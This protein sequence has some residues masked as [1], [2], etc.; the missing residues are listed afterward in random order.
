MT[1]RE[2][3]EFLSDYLSNDLSVVEKASFEE[4]VRECAACTRYLEGFAATVGL[5]RE[6]FADPE[7][8]VPGDVPEELVSAIVSARRRS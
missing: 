1:C 7:A 3:V 5:S 8:P 2:L 4:H 6:A